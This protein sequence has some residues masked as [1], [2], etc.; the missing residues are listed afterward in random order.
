MGGNTT[1]SYGRF[2]LAE[3]SDRRLQSARPI[4]PEVLSRVFK[5]EDL[6]AAA[7]ADQS[8]CSSGPAALSTGRRLRWLKWSACTRA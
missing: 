5:R 3:H 1:Q 7:R 4:G 6:S 2:F 8:V